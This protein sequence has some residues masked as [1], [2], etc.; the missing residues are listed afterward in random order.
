M[1]VWQGSDSEAD[2]SFQ[3]LHAHWLTGFTLLGKEQ[4]FSPE[5]T[6]G[7]VSPIMKIGAIAELTE[8]WL[9]VVEKKPNAFLCSYKYI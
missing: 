3:L 7:G 6:A 2:L 1:R 8:G 5:L 4:R 9:Y